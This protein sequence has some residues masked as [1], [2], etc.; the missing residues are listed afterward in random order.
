MK[1]APR[2]ARN[3]AE[4]SKLAGMS[5]VTFYHL[6]KM[7]GFPRPKADG[8]WCV[9]EIRRFALKAAKKIEGPNERDRLGME[10][11]NLKIKR[12]SQELAEFEAALREQISGPMKAAFTKASYAIRSGIYR[13]RV[14]LSPRFSGMDARSIFKMWEQRERQLWG[15]VCADLRKEAGAQIQEPETRADKVLIPFKQSKNGNGHSAKGTVA[16]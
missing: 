13:M 2:F 5:R 15:I 12:A 4:A 1:A 14:E 7:P 9:S 6:E 3:K 10:L 16:G 8:R 11:L